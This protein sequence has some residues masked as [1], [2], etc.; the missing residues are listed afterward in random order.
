[1][2]DAPDKPE[3]PVADQP[4]AAQPA[5]SQ[6]AGPAGRGVQAYERMKAMAMSRDG[7]VRLDLARD[8]EAPAELLFYL[9]DD[10]E[11]EVLKAV[12]ANPATPLRAA[13]RLA[14]DRR[15]DVRAL[16]GGKVARQLPTLQPADQ[17]ALRAVAEHALEMLAAD[18][19]AR[20]RAAVAS[21][22]KDVDCAPPQLIAKLARDV[23]REV[24]EPVLRSCAQ[25][26]D[27]ELMAILSSRAEG[28]GEG[29]VA[30]AIAGRASLSAPVVDAVLAVDDPEADRLLAANPGAEIG[31][32]ALEML[33]DRARVDADLQAPLAA[34]PGLPPRIALRLAEHVDEAVRRILAER[35]DFDTETRAAIAGV[36]GRRLDF[37]RDYDGREPAEDKALRLFRAGQLNEAAVWDALA[38]SDRAFVRAALA[39]LAGTDVATVDRLLATASPKAVTALAWRAGLSMRCA[40]E[41]QAKGARI[42]PRQLLNA[43]H[44]TDYPLTEAEM[45]WQLDFFDIE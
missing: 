6:A 45:R 27:A 35:G 7:E 38:W 12:A 34:R 18:Q 22:I 21:A 42:P 30:Q 36:A 29:W 2:S 33:A 1:M 3:S 28:Q 43:R 39:L 4:A 44:G 10:D 24:A 32:T 13:P 16:L 14:R 17:E 9:S 23:A 11:P 5:A 40:R 41:L 15:E 19:V 8:P 20:V 31:E 25:L 37:A 26:S